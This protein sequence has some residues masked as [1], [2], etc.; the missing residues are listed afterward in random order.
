MGSPLAHAPPNLVDEIGTRPV[1]EELVAKIAV[2][3]PMV[4]RY[5]PADRYAKVPYR[6]A[7]VLLGPPGKVVGRVDR[8]IHRLTMPPIQV[9]YGLADLALLLRVH[10]GGGQEAVGLPTR[11][12]RL[13]LGFRKLL[14]R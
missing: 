11:D 5:P 10:R 3:S 14:A 9:I 8:A 4:V 12:G 7:E 13:D 1:G 6:R 2:L